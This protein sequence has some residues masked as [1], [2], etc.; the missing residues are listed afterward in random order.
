MLDTILVLLLFFFAVLLF[1][2]LIALILY[3]RK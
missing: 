1:A 3:L 2:S